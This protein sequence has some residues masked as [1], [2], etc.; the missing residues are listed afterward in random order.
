MNF[1]VFFFYVLKGTMTPIDKFYLRS[2]K[3]G[4][5]DV[6]RGTPL[7]CRQGPFARCCNLVME[8]ETN[9][10]RCHET[11]AMEQVPW[12]MCH[13]VAMEH[14][15][16]TMCR[17]A[18]AIVILSW[19]PAVGYAISLPKHTFTAVDASKETLRTMCLERSYDIETS[20]RC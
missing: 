14:V 15:P 13:E 7:P 8:T 18:V 10:A 16:W 17:G 9:F 19:H 5:F 2:R 6:T 1:I 3:V 4:P 20:F 12:S 11:G